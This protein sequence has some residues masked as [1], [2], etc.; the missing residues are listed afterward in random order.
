MKQMSRNG[1]SKGSKKDWLGDLDTVPVGSIVSQLPITVSLPSTVG[2]IVE[3]M[4]AK[5]ISSVVAV[6]AAFCPVGIFTEHDALRCAAEGN[7]PNQAAETIMSTDVLCADDSVSLHSAYGMMEERGVHHLIVTGANGKLLGVVTEGDFLRHIG[8]EHLSRFKS[9][10]DAMSR[11]VLILEADTTVLVAAQAI[12]ERRTD[13]AVVLA[14]GHPVGV[15]SERDIARWYAMRTKGEEV[16]ISELLSGEFRSVT[17]T[18]PLHTAAMMMEEHGIHQLIVTDET[19]ALIGYVNRHDV[20]HAIHGAYYEYL[21]RVIE[22]KSATISKMTRLKGE[23]RKEKEHYRKSELKLRKL[24]EALPDGVMLIDSRTMRAVE[25]NRTAHEQLGY[26]AEEFARLD[27]HDYEAIESP[28]ETHRRKEAILR[29]GHDTFE[30]VHRR[31]TGELI[32]VWVNVM[33]VELDGAPHFIAVSRDI[34]DRKKKDDEIRR[35]QELAHIGTWEWEIPEDRFIG[36]PECMRIYGL[37]EG[38]AVSITEVRERVHPEDRQWFDDEIT[39]VLWDGAY[40]TRYRVADA[41]GGIRW[42]QAHAE[43]Q[44][45]DAGRRIKGIGIVQDIS[46]R[47]RHEEELRR[48]DADLSEAQSLAQVGSWRLDIR[49]NLLEWSDETYR[50]FGIEKGTPISYYE[51]FLSSIHPDDAEKV[52]AAW[53]AALK[54]SRYDV[55]HRIVV[56][57]EIKWVREKARLETDE[58]GEL[59]SGVGTVQVITE[60]KLYEERLERLANYDPL[61]GL[62]NRSLLMAQLNKTIEKGNRHRTRTALIL[63]DLDRFKDVNDSFGHGAGDELLKQASKRFLERLREGDL[64]ARLGGDEFAVILEEVAHAEDAGRIAQEVLH[65]LSAPY[66]LSSGAEVHIGAS[67]GIVLH[68]LHGAESDTLFQHADAAL[69]KAKAQGRGSYHYYT[70]DLTETARRRLL[71]ESNLRRAI[72]RNEFVVY[73]QPQVHIETGRIVGAE[74]LVRWKDPERG[75]VSPGE[76]IPIAEET[77]LIRDIGE[78]VLGETCRQGKEWLERGHRLTLAVNLSANQVRHQDILNVVNGALK[79]SGYPASRLEL[80]LTESALM[81]REEETVAM[82]HSLRAMGIRLAI[83]DFGTGY[84]SLS[85]LKRFPIDVLKIDKSFVDDIPFDQDDNAIVSAI[86]AMAQALGYQVLAEGTERSE[87]IA[88]LREKGCALYQGYF[89]SPPLPAEAF[90]ALI[91]SEKNRSVP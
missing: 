48:K 89:K 3:L 10:T 50:I 78:W 79:R 9:V 61:T 64:I 38:A 87:Q 55:E 88:F 43:F 28:E 74:A 5:E 62:A 49:D 11:S 24:F 41:E 16:A 63:F 85:Y 77:G 19:D 80:E 70:D 33:T 84:S 17:R 4:A 51:S 29:Q 35:V 60:R 46:G 15:L 56:G 40:H 81:E 26:G 36:S 57:D 47:I 18:T 37:P 1:T 14:S 86:I 13:H 75:M 72:E 83:D 65:S 42:V 25:F 7:D 69:Y 52:N 34:T 53:M 20:L 6:D 12:R 32:D 8:F 90:E 67:A 66:K 30:T 44:Y 73:Y 23:L 82:L 91:V 27:V 39:R 59:L 45:D 2:D 22:G 21:M 54:G 58:G 68:P 76:F 31:K 71:C